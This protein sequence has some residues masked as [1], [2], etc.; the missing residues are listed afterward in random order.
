MPTYRVTDPTTG[1]VVKLTGDSPPTERELEE[2][3]TQLTGGTPAPA[4]QAASWIPT[5]QEP[6]SGIIQQT[7]D[8]Y[9]KPLPDNKMFSKKYLEENVVPSVA[10]IIPQALTGIVAM[11]YNAAKKFTDPIYNALTGQQELGAAASDL[12]NAPMNV[13]KEFVNGLGQAIG[14]PLGLGANKG[15]ANRAWNDPAAALAAVAPVVGVAGR[16][17]AAAMPKDIALGL[18]KKSLKFSPG[19]EPDLQ[20]RVAKTVLEND[21]ST[22]GASYGEFKRTIKDL[23]ESVKGMIEPVSG[24]KITVTPDSWVQ[25]LLDKAM[26]SG[27]KT[28]DLAEITQFLEEF[29]VDH[30]ELTV[31]EAQKVKISLN[32]KLEAF[33]KA[34][35]AGKSTENAAR[36]DAMRAVANG[37]RG[38]IEKFAPETRETNQQIHEMLIAKPFLKTAVNKAE[39]QPTFSGRDMITGGVAGMMTTNPAVG[40]ATMIGSRLLRDPRVQSKAAVA[41]DSISDFKVKI[42]KMLSPDKATSIVAEFENSPEGQKLLP[43]PERGFEMRNPEDVYSPYS[44][45]LSKN[46]N[47]LALPP[48]ERGFEMRSPEDVYSP[49]QPREVGTWEKLYKM[50]QDPAGRRALIEK[51]GK[52]EKYAGILKKL[53]DVEPLEALPG[54]G[55]RNLLDYSP[56]VYSPRKQVWKI[57]ESGPYMDQ[58]QQFQIQPSGYVQQVPPAGGIPRPNALGQ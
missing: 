3:F 47:Q 29:K 25:R 26:T 50:A 10:R 14:A 32:K 22:T 41:L 37:L 48:G 13:T 57:G 24:E 40:T 16:G 4:M 11:P 9:S 34:R 2:V 30:P 55:E 1:K 46:V 39:N 27:E 58:V 53:L 56:N 31:G 20:N 6:A 12:W 5:T 15:D 35:Q 18:T 42:G 51:L 8:Q 38:E 36:E 43:A 23:N 49:F 33:E 7:F 54:V 19:V 21:T 45:E 44:P 28:K 52:E 17:A